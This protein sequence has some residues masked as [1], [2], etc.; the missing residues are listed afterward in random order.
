MLTLTGK[1]L[2]LAALSREDCRTLYRDDEY[3]FAALTEPLYIGQSIES[4]DAWY[5]DIQARQ[6]KENIRLGIFLK[7]GG[8]IG[9]VALQNIDWRNRSCDVGM[10]IHKTANRGQGFGQ[11]ALGLMLVYAFDNLGLERVEASTLA[12]NIGAR[13][14]L[15][16][17]GFLLEGTQREA[18][19]F[20]AK[21]HDR[22]LYALLAR[23]YRAAQP[24]PGP[25]VT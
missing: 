20:A 11:E 1:R 6:Q 8:V 24:A 2:Y 22:L 17:L 14:S 5:E 18:V 15:E 21:R 13:R 25:S 12:P 16:A 19:Y 10:G 3:D 7:A 4:A 23:E 9:D